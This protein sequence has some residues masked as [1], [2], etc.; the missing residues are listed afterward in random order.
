VYF[1]STFP[2]YIVAP[3]IPFMQIT[4]GLPSECCDA[5]D[6]IKLTLQL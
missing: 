2:T 1:F 4:Y 6:K 5:M 3:G